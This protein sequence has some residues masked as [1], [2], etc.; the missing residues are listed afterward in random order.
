MQMDFHY[1]ATYC[2]AFIAGY[3]H[4]E[5]CSIAYSAQFVDECSLLLINKLKAPRAAATTQL[6][7]E[8]MDADTDIM[9]LQDITRIWAS[10]HFLPQDLY[11]QK[12]WRTKRYLRKYRLLCGP[13]GSLLRETVDLAKGR[14]LQAAGL[15]MH[16]LADTW[17]HRYFAGTPSLAINNTDYYFYEIFP[18]G[19]EKQIKFRHSPTQPDDLENSIYTSSLY[20]SNENSIMNLG[21]GRAGHLPDYSFCRYKY[22]PAWGDYRE[23]IKDN[24]SDYFNAFCQ[25]I[26]AMKYLKGDVETFELDTYDTEAVKPY[27]DEIKAIICERRPNAS[28]GWRAFGERLSGETIPVYDINKYQKEYMDSDNKEDTFLGGFFGAAVRQKSMVTNR[29]LTSHSL[30]PGYSVTPGKTSLL[31]ALLKLIKKEEGKVE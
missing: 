25:M 24:P 8:L 18:D 21:H 29:I 1:Y 14:G 10:F 30:L 19:T 22:L 16:I 28:D 31:G 23:I 2:A 9:G 6:Q 20:Q 3:S 7:T 4:K 11:A 12:K 5:S 26:Y 17:A 15:A 27:R 13:N